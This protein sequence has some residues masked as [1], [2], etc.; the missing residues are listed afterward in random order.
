MNNEKLRIKNS[1]FVTTNRDAYETVENNLS[2]PCLRA[3][4][5]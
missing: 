4:D 5:I 1:I 2:I 3:H